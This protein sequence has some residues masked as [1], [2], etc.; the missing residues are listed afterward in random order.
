MKFKS[1]L[2]LIISCLGC[3]IF[4]QQIESLGDYCSQVDRIQIVE[5]FEECSHYLNITSD[6]QTNHESNDSYIYFSRILNNVL[7]AIESNNSTKQETK[8]L[9]LTML[10]M[11][12]FA[13]NRTDFK[14]C[15]VSLCSLLKN[16][17]FP[18][19]I[20]YKNFDNIAMTAARIASILTAYT[21]NEKLENEAFLSWQQLN[22]QLKLTVL[23][24]ENIYDGKIIFFKSKNKNNNNNENFKSI[25]V[26]KNLDTKEISLQNYE[27]DLEKSKNFQWYHVWDTRPVSIFSSKVMS[28]KSGKI[29]YPISSEFYANRYVSDVTYDCL[30]SVWNRIVSVPFFYPSGEIR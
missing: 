7:N 20:S 2:L 19:E 1:Q 24:N 3:C 28:S 9:F 16:C 18:L 11:A 21:F 4:V 12:E 30:K 26:S 6:H 14:N 27:L 29:F 10:K 25:H 22:T 15:F 17:E 13:N 8:H 23:D 5:K